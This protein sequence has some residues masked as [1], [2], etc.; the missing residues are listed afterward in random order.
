M[1]SLEERAQR[2]VDLEDELHLHETFWGAGLCST[3]LIIPEY[4]TMIALCEEILP[5]VPKKPEELKKHIA[6]LKRNRRKYVKHREEEV[7]ELVRERLDESGLEH[8]EI[9]KVERLEEDEP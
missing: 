4:D 1:M 5:D 6:K 3:S 9:V 8:V 2:I 7:T